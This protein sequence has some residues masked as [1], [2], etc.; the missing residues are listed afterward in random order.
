MEQYSI[1]GACRAGNETQVTSMLNMGA[2]PCTMHNA[3]TTSI[4]RRLHKAGA[5][6][7]AVDSVGLTVLHRS[8][9]N[10]VKVKYLLDAGAK[11]SSARSDMVTPIHVALW[12]I[13][14]M[15]FT[16]ENKQAI[17]AMMD[18]IRL[19]VS[20][21]MITLYA[22]DSE[23]NDAFAYAADVFDGRNNN[24]FRMFMGA[25]RMDHK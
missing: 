14:N 17:T 4:M 8:M 21:S 22:K 3:R 9:D 12:H 7:D 15:A 1:A 23:G 24:K 20:R 25:T 11:V 5:D 2:V 13:A 6:I 16:H 18:S 10:P 19:V